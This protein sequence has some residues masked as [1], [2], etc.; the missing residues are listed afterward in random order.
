VLV[1]DDEADL[2][3]LL[4]L[5]LVGMGLDVDCAADLGQA[6]K[7][8]VS[9][10]YD[11]C[12][13]DMRL[14]DGD[15]LSLVSEIGAAHPETP[16]AVI[17]AFGSA[18]TAVAALKAGAFD[19]LPK[20]VALDALRT[21]VRSALRL[22]ALG[23]P[24][25]HS[26]TATNAAPVAADRL[27]GV[28]SPR[29]PVGQRSVDAESGGY[30]AASP[31]PT[32]AVGPGQLLGASSAIEVVRESIGRLARSMAPVAITG[33]SG[34]GK[35]LVARLI[36]Q[37]GSRADQP[38]VAV[39]CGAIPEAL[40][41]SEFFGHRRGAFTGADQ[42]RVGFF[43]A[44]SGGTLFLDE[45]ADLPLAMQVKLLRAIQ[46]RCVRRVGATVEEPVDV[47]IV[48]ATHQDLARCVAEGRFRQDLYY[49]LNV[50]ELRVPALRERLTDIPLLANA[51][52]S[53]LA[54]RAG[55]RVTPRLSSITQSYLQTYQ[56]PGNVRELE[57]ILERAIAFSN[58]EVINVE[59]LGLRPDSVDIADDEAVDASSGEPSSTSISARLSGQS[60]SVAGPSGPPVMSDD[61]IPA[62]LP[63]YLEWLERE[64]IA[65]ALEKTRQNRTAAARLL[66]IS[67]RALRHRMQRLDI[68]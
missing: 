56:F 41:E 11:L 16:V 34:S 21:L 23:D 47:R 25:A 45:V 27:A 19:Y 9:W 55:L 42:D 67:F 58:G 1:V 6:R 48:S 14:P 3:E 35:E 52:L 62:S 50:I 33:E 5:T 10:R 57:N 13:T 30:P 36:H 63:N 12:L 22:P 2:R 61:G 54:G 49:R 43:Q 65:R 17:T 53:K 68:Q 46:E 8:L 7:L 40:M 31:V 64:A 59:D 39:N 37:G 44:A 20:P 24:S 18:E 66:G 28:A 15:G 32:R 38:F 60:D 51:L 29:L 4:E 26:H